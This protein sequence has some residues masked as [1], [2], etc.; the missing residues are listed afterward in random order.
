[1]DLKDALPTFFRPLLPSP[2]RS[3]LSSQRFS[4]VMEFPLK[5]PYER[6]S[7]ILSRLLY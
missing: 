6:H 2:L 7:C 5:F 1:M 3:D 4:K